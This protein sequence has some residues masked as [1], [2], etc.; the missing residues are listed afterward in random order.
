[1]SLCRGCEARV[2]SFKATRVLMVIRIIRLIAIIRIMRMF[3]GNCS[4]RGFR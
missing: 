3:T 1:V 4:F 2:S